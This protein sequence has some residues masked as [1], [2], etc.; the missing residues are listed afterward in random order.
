MIFFKLK[1]FLATV[2]TVTK[3]EIVY[4]TVTSDSIWCQICA[5]L[6]KKLTIHWWKILDGFKSVSWEVLIYIY[7]GMEYFQHILRFRWIIELRRI[8]RFTMT[9]YNN[10]QVIFDNRILCNIHSKINCMKKQKVLTFFAL[11]Q[12]YSSWLYFDLLLHIFRYFSNE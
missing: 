8:W 7:I 5:V 3:L 6:K 12:G 2:V 11:R 9:Y 1:T 4:I 10:S